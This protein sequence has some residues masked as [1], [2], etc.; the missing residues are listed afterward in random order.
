MLEG[1][2]E[3]EGFS[4]LFAVLLVLMI[5]AVAIIMGSFFGMGFAVQFGEGP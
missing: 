5:S 3:P 1:V 2:S 4:V